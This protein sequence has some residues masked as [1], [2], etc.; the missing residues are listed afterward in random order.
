MFSVILILMEDS[1][2][3]SVTGNVFFAHF[4]LTPTPLPRKFQSK[5][6]NQFT[7]CA[8]ADVDDS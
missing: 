1:Q 2:I 3:D 7:L 8:L 4:S 6:D 5:I